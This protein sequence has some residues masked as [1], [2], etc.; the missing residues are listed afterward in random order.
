MPAARSNNRPF[1]TSV[2]GPIG[3]RCRQ[4]VQP[5][6]ALP[7]SARLAQLC[8]RLDVSAHSAK[9]MLATHLQANQTVYLYVT[10][11]PVGAD[12]LV[13]DLRLQLNLPLPC[14]L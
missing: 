2:E 8:V 5:P 14:L 10:P 11:L 4:P 6:R 9:F 7:E 1:R 3:S 12:S 13:I